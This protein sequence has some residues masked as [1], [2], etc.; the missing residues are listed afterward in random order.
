MLFVKWKCVLNI[1]TRIIQEHTVYTY[2]IVSFS[3]HHKTGLYVVEI[4]IKH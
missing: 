1:R 4:E 3:Y 2:T